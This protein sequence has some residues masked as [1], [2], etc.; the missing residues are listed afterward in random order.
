MN[1]RRHLRFSRFCLVPAAVLAAATGFAAP[2]PD[3][4]VTQ[5]A[6]ANT[7]FAVDLYRQLAATPGNLFFS[8]YS[9]SRVLAMAAAGARG[10]TATEM[11]AALHLNAPADQAAAGYAA[12]TKTLQADAGGDLTLVTADS[13]WVQDQFPLLDAY[14][15]VVQTQFGAEARPADFVHHAE[16]ARTAINGW[17]SDQTRG[18]I[19][20]LIAPG[21]LT[22]DTRVVLCDAIYFLGTW[23]HQFEARQT[24][25]EPFH[26]SP[27]S[28][29]DVS[30]MHQTSSFRSA[31]AGNV[32][33]LE[34][35]Y[36]G[37]RL[38]MVVILPDA[39]DGLPGL[40]QQLTEAQLRG[41]LAQLDSGTA[42]RTSVFVP[43]F[44]ARD[45]LELASTLARLGMARA[46]DR[47]A[48]D[49]SGMAQ[50][51]AFW[52]SAVVHQAFV[53]VDE[54][55]TEAAAASAVIML[56]AMAVQEQL[57][58]FLVDHPF[59][60]LIRDNATG[61]ILFLGRIVDPR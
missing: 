4:A 50:G 42:V 45:N 25:P 15:R 7:A 49:F 55:G 6:A 38:S 51:G 37:Q 43:R 48:A 58:E 52:L 30:M 36:L 40:E 32:G 20:T 10:A 54:E 18:K 56:E 23:D 8:P 3:P 22:A 59:L 46:F 9:L 24:Q 28:A 41:W 31:H 12:L 27:Q 60:F 33:L 26:L 17:V 34:L 39:I 61:T 1:M 11:G 5:V 21:M 35:P 14:R 47:K 53:K 19:P 57:P 29:A 13:L 16:D 2:A 44:T